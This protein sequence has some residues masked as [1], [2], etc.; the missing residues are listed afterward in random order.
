MNTVPPLQFT[1]AGV[2]VPSEID[3]LAAVQADMNAV[4]G[5]NLSANLETPQGQI[6]SSTTAIIAASYAAMLN[7]ANNLD[8]AYASGR[9]QD[10]I[11]RFY[12]I[13]RNPPEATVIQVS[14]S[15]LTGVTIPVNALVQDTVGNLYSC[16]QAGTIPNGGSITLPFACTTIGTVS[17]PSS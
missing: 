16:T 12:F 2:V 7:L 1:P 15:G 4:F 5:G 13:T 3:I 9:F 17:V 8:P 6:A 14:C 11:G 10:A